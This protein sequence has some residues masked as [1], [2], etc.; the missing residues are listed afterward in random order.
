MLC[1]CFGAPVNKGEHARYLVELREEMV[2]SITGLSEEKADIS[3]GVLLT[4][5]FLPDIIV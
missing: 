5:S 4:L 3:P 2:F 1:P